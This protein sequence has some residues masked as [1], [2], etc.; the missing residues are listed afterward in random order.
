MNRLRTIT[1]DRLTTWDIFFTIWFITE[2]CSYHSIFNTIAVLMF[3]AVSLVYSFR[4]KI[5]LSMLLPWMC[6]FILISWLNVVMGYSINPSNSYEMIVTLLKNLLFLVALVAY[7][8][9]IGIERFKN[10]FI[11]AAFISSIL[12]F[13]MSFI[14]TGSLVVRRN[15][16]SINANYLAVCCS[17]V[18]IIILSNSNISV[19]RRF[20]HIIYLALFGILAGTRKA[21]LALIIGI[22]VFF[23]AKYPKRLLKNTIITILIL[24]GV[25]YAL[26]RIPFLYNVLG[27]RF[28]SALEFVNG[29]SGDSSIY[30]RS[31]YIQKGI[32]EF[33]KSP[34]WG[35]G[36]N[37]FKTLSGTLETYSHN[38]YVELLFSVGLIGTIG[39]YS[40]H[41][42]TLIFAVLK[43]KETELINNCLCLAIIAIVVFVDYSMVSYYERGSLIYIVLFYML[44]SKS[45][46][47]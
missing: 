41:F 43:R 17:V 8:H 38:N 18:S 3:I 30:M 22:I 7:V 4:N 42:L 29:Q 31:F 12:I 44:I 11:I 33:Q 40:L 27:S 15:S 25:Y 10:S 6:A 2:Y 19:S 35:R 9:G 13:L 5:H 37:C 34:I 14:N 1:I 46:L 26:T 21:I 20:W 45:R 36:I 32:S 47:A 39:F 24:F 23:C 28:V 16:G